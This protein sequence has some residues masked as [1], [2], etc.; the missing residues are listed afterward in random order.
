MCVCVGL[1][2]CA[3]HDPKQ[4]RDS[5]H[6][7]ALHCNNMRGCHTC[8]VAFPLSSISSTGES[9]PSS[10]DKHSPLNPP[11]TDLSLVSCPPAAAH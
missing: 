2:L 5:L 3:I 7:E 9:Q 10:H 1:A 8:K 4:C 11:F 6:F